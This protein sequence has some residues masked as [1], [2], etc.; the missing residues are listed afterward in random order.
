M[1]V[2]GMH[3]SRVNAGLTIEKK[4]IA[5]ANLLQWKYEYF[6]GPLY[7]WLIFHKK[8]KKKILVSL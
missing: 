6:L 4:K 1:I 7:Y 8:E 5:I 3:L 2:I